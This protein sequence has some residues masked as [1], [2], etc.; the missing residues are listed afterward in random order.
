[1][2]LKDA[3][4]GH[5]LEDNYEEALSLKNR[6]AFLNA[7]LFPNLSEQEQQYVKELEDLA[8]KWEPKVLEH[9]DDVYPLFPLLLE[10][11]T[12]PKAFPQEEVTERTKL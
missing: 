1:M 10:S 2:E 7:N 9:L 6:F 8:I 4:I 11:Y 5:L 3:K 12:V